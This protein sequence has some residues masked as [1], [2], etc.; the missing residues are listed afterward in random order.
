MCSLFY[1]LYYYGKALLDKQF[2]TS[3]ILLY[4]LNN[5]IAYI[6]M[7]LKEECGAFEMNS[8]KSEVLPHR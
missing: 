6:S 3:Q 7:S 8:K 2:N 1:T 4:S 5:Q